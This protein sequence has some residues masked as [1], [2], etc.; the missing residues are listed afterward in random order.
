MVVF[1]PQKG[2]GFSNGIIQIGKP[3]APL[4]AVVLQQLI[5]FVALSIGALVAGVV[6]CWFAWRS[7]SI[8]SGEREAKEQMK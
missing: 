1:L 3:T 2:P 7:H 4:K 6:L 8:R 5:L